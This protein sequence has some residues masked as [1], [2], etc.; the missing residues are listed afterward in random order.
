MLDALLANQVVRAVLPGCHLLLALA[1]AKPTRGRTAWSMQLLADGLVERGVAGGISDKTVRR[2]LKNLD[3][4]P[5]HRARF[6]DRA[7]L[8]SADYSRIASRECSS[9]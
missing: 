9:S 1:C 3:R 5:N 6:S 7:T 4:L 8:S 2:T